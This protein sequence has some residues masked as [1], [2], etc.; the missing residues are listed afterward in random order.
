M[1]VVAELW[2]T[3]GVEGGREV[4][5]P[6]QLDSLNNYMHTGEEGGG[7]GGTHCYSN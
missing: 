3:G 1:E 2:G 5:G 4:A 6:R 7:D